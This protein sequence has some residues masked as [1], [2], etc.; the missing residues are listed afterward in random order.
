MSFKKYVEKIEF[1]TV[2]P[3]SNQEIIF[4]PLKTRQLKRLSSL[5]LDD[6]VLIET[7]ID[8]IINE[9]ISNEV[10]VKDLYLYDRTF[11]AMKIRA[12]TKGEIHSTVVKCPKCN[13]ESLNNINLD[14]L[15]IIPKSIPENNII[16]YNDEIQ[17]KIDNIV[18]KDQ[19]EQ[20]K[21]IDQTNIN[22][23]GLETELKFATL[24]AAIKSVISPDGEEELTPE[25]KKWLIE[26]LP[27]SIIEQ[28]DNWL[29]DNQF[30]ID[31]IYTLKCIHCGEELGKRKVD[32]DTPFL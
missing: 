9:C 8:D 23:N 17:I 7:V 32:L 22:N 4:K 5:N 20:Y 25:D 30:G 27:P 16:K 3:G 6:L 29:K 24:A 2:T 28:I 15:T 31:F 11:L 10:N 26:E 19:E 14:D 12:K 1:K 13:S 21:L 18:R